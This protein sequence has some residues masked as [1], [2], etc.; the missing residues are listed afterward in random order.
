M[1]AIPT[2]GHD[3]SSAELDELETLV[4]SWR[5]HLR[6]QRMSPATLLTYTTAVRQLARF[7]RTN[8]MPTA[9]AAIRRE[10]VETWITELLERWK[11]ATAHNRYRAAHTFF[12]W[13]VEEGEISASPMARMKPPRLPEVPPPVLRETELRALFAVCERDRSF[14]GRRDEAIIRTLADTGIRRSELLGVQLADVDLEH[15]VLR[16]TGKGSRT[17]EVAIGDLTVRALDRYLRLRARHKAADLPWLWLG[18]D[19]QMRESGL[20]D[21]IHARGQEAGF[22]RRIHPHDFRHAYAHHW[23]SAG[24]QESDLMA[25]AGWRTTEM[26]RR[27]AAATR[28][29]RALAAARKLSPVDRISGER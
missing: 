2:T 28:Q 19:R 3:T 16:V 21:L 26:V 29:E 1:T 24:G 18:R 4:D 6:A 22:S 23:L 17:R 7:L 5:R 14:A 27:Y 9:V 13:L 12:G 20:G 11:P 8:G 25:I 15:G 10:H